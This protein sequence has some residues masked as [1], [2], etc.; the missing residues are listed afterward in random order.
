MRIYAKLFLGL[1]WLLT[2]LFLASCE[3]LRFNGVFYLGESD[4]ELSTLL[5]S[6][7][8][9][10][11]DHGSMGLSISKYPYRAHYGDN[12]KIYIM[13]EEGLFLYNKTSKKYEL[14]S[15]ENHFEYSEWNYLQPTDI[16]GEMYYQ[17]WGSLYRILNKEVSLIQTGV[18]S[19]VGFPFSSKL[20][21]LRSDHQTLQLYDGVSLQ[22]TLCFLPARAERAFYFEEADLVVYLN[23]LTF[24][25]C[26]T[27]GSEKT[28]LFRVEP[29]PSSNFVFC[30]V[31][32]MG[33]F[34]TSSRVNNQD[35]LYMVDALSGTNQIIGTTYHSYV[36]NG[37]SLPIQVSLSGDRTKLM[38]YDPSAL[39]FL[40][41]NSMTTEDITFDDSRNYTSACLNED[42]SNFV[43]LA[44][45]SQDYTVNP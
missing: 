15:K 39:H 14:I 3:Q 18:R 26:N 4:G 30:P 27:D 1:I 6:I 34:V 24:Y 16:P 23:F 31:D 9:E 33:R 44:K 29:A 28:Q 2:S 7:D 20:S 17:S 22:D 21:V 8:F 11:I 40:D 41:L 43:F 32:K 25:S 38:Y 19:C 42:G 10:V 35:T 45:I 36:P 13:F 5:S 12:Q 37:N